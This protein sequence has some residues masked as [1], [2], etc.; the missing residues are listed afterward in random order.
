MPEEIAPQGETAIPFV[1]E[2][3]APSKKVETR[4]VCVALSTDVEQVVVRKP[5]WV[6]ALTSH[7]W[8]GIGCLLRASHCP[9]PARKVTPSSL[10]WQ[11]NGDCVKRLVLREEV[12]LRVG[13]RETNLGRIRIRTGTTEQKKEGTLSLRTSRV[14]RAVPPGLARSP[15]RPPT[16]GG[17][18]RIRV[19]AEV[20]NT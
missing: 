3:I 2:T 6:P 20:G 11:G 15:P 7:A 5:C 16:P 4:R 9:R 8:R 18:S 12:R 1:E 10:Q 13:K 14:N 19:D 17:A